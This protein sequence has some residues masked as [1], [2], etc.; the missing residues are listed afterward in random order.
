MAPWWAWGALAFVFF[1]VALELGAAQFANSRVPA[2]AETLT[3]LAWPQ[4]ARALW[5]LAV[6]AAATVFRYGEWRAGVARSRLVVAASV[7]PFFVFALGVA[8]GAEFATW[9]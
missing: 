3:P 1:A 6:A 9:H 4:A 2:L 8:L 5:W 7:V